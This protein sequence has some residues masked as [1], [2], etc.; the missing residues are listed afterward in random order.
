MFGKEV[1]VHDG[2]FD[3]AS[4]TPLA[5]R[6][7]KKLISVYKLQRKGTAGNSLATHPVGQN[8]EKILEKARKLISSNVGIKSRNIL[9]THSATLGARVAVDSIVESAKENG[10]EYK[11]MN[12]VV[13]GTEH[14]CMPRALNNVV[15]R[16]G[17]DIRVVKP[18][19]NGLIKLESVIDLVDKNTVGVSIQYVN[20]EYGLI[21]DIKKIFDEVKKKNKDTFTLTDAAQGG[22]YFNISPYALNS[23]IVV[24][25]ST[26]MFGPQ[27]AGVN[28]FKSIDDFVGMS[29]EKSFWDIYPGTPAVA[30]LASFS[31]AFD[32]CH[33]KRDVHM[34]KLKSLRLFLIEKLKERFPESIVHGV[35]KRLKDI[36][37]KDLEILSPHITH[38]N[39]P[40]VDHAY[41]PVLLGSKG[42]S[43]SRKAAC[44]N[45]N[46]VKS[47]M[48]DLGDAADGI[49][50]S[51]CPYVSKK[52]IQSLV[53][54]LDKLVEIAKKS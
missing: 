35:G 5:N 11:D 51:L 12:F 27:G 18:D 39:F 46:N 2:Y 33:K 9:F 53:S 14:D 24:L 4:F 42:F 54:H 8:S 41:L 48:D 20:G 22:A 50:I 32:F 13:G 19:S 43:V 49:R 30:T 17:I 3:F 10:K 7:Y 16:R 52:S 23:D 21:Y 6:A 34:N 45:G 47:F 36:K 44:L 25:D 26:K 38:I 31:T 1:S 15:K 29:G 28:I 37:E 40:N